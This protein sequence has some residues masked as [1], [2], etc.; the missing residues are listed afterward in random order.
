M[1][2]L[3]QTGFVPWSS[4]RIQFI[5]CRPLFL[6][7]LA[8]AL[9]CVQDQTPTV[10]AS[11]QPND[12]PS[13]EIDAAARNLI[14]CACANRSGGINYAV[15]QTTKPAGFTERVVFVRKT[16]RCFPDLQYSRCERRFRSWL[17]S[18]SLP[19]TLQNR[20]GYK[21]KEQP[22]VDWPAFFRPRLPFLPT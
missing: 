5:D 12:L 9:S 20:L 13:D 10:S 17:R 7:S 19:L 21:K 3:V 15:G 1:I 6:S 11:T 22:L 16:F 18:K 2:L 4:L 14:V 8:E